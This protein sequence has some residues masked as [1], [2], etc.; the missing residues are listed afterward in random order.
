MAIKCIDCKKYKNDVLTANAGAE[1]CVSD[2][3]DRND[4]EQDWLHADEDFKEYVEKERFCSEFKK[5]AL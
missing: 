4:E 2:M 5:L 3:W 1:Y